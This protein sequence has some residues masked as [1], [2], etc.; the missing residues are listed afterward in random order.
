MK[1]KEFQRKYEDY[2]RTKE[3]FNLTEV[4]YYLDRSPRQIH[5]LVARKGLPKH[6]GKGKGKNGVYIRK[7]IDKWVRDNKD[8]YFR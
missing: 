2:L 6:G 7:E 1:P 4:A 3:R 8:F 5:Y